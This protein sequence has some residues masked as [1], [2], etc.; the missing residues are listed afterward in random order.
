MRRVPEE[1]GSRNT[2]SDKSQRNY[3]EKHEDCSWTLRGVDWPTESFV[4]IQR[5]ECQPTPQ[6]TQRSGCRKT[7]CP[8][9]M[10]EKKHHEKDWPGNKSPEFEEYVRRSQN[11]AEGETDE[12]SEKHSYVCPPEVRQQWS[13]DDGLPHSAG[14]DYFQRL[15]WY[16]R[17]SKA[18]FSPHAPMA[19]SYV[20]MPKFGSCGMTSQ[21]P[22]HASRNSYQLT[23]RNAFCG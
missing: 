12:N 10:V 15:T 13:V 23:S 3:R 11:V 18:S 20:R 4:L 22:V 7:A 17:L 16:R 1:G 14:R 2:G 8:A 6:R 9:F 5:H 19:E 21:Q